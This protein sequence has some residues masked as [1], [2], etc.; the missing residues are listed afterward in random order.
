MISKDLLESLLLVIN[1]KKIIK[2]YKKRCIKHGYH[3]AVCMSGSKPNHG[4]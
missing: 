4:L 1:S 3:A 2:R